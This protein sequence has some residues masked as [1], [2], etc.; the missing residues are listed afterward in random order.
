VG[1]MSVPI[2]CALQGAEYVAKR[3][4]CIGI[5]DCLEIYVEDEERVRRS[6]SQTFACAAR[7]P[8]GGARKLSDY[9][10]PDTPEGCEKTED[11]I[12][13]GYPARLISNRDLGRFTVTPGTLREEK[14][15]SKAHQER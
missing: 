14:S 6:Y 8:R 3:V 9:L 1:V 7:E 11:G 12:E 10:C 4:M 13:V 5:A 2:G 15:D